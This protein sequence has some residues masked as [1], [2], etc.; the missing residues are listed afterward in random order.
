MNIFILAGEPSGDEYGAKLMQ[1]LVAQEANI[2]FIGIGGPLMQKQGLKSIAPLEKMSVM[3]FFEI[4]KTLSFFL[5]LEKNILN[6]IAEKT[7]SKIILIDYP[8]LNLRLAPKIKS[9][10][11]TQIFYYISPQIWAWKE[12]RIE[13]IKKYIDKMIVIFEFEKNGIK[14]EM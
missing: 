6:L 12:K 4:I 14:K 11:D 7:P 2:N 3:G 9:L 1:N 13:T 8:G 5:K 10:I